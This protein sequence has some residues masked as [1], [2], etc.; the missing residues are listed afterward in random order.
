[1][2]QQDSRKE[3]LTY[4]NIRR[5]LRRRLWQS[6]VLLIVCAAFSVGFIWAFH[7]V[8]ELLFERGT[9]RH[10][11]LPGW[12]MLLAIP[13]LLYV[14]IKEAW[15]ITCGFRRKPYLVK[16]RLIS[17]D[18]GRSY[19]S[20]R[21]RTFMSWGVLRFNGYGDYKVPDTNYPWSK[22]YPMTSDGVYHTSFDGDEFYLV[23]S[24]PHNGKILLA[25]PAKYF[26]LEGETP[27][28]E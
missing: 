8:P 5:D 6:W 10:S 13:F 15:L 9:G 20:T 18:E 11:H 16:D 14:C 23:L 17:S 3:I 12:V 22:E 4:A 2:K 26:Q 7:Q 21:W 19:T 25:Y 27:T 24:K 1:M 28:E